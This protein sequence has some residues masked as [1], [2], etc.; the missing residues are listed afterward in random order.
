[1]TENDGMGLT[2]LKNFK[3]FTAKKAAADQIFEDLTPTILNKHL[4]SLMDGLSAKVFRT[5]NASKTL[6]D[7]LAKTEQLESWSSLSETQK[8]DEYNAANRV[9]AI[10]CNHQKSVSAAGQ[11]SLDA[12]SEKVEKLREQKKVSGGAESE[13]GNEEGFDEDI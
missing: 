3:T 4:S 11:A 1:Y 13:G 7:E 6:Q 9:V 5:Y 12:S 10:L 2:V 8:V